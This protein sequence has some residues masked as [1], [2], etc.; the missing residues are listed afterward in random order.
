MGR[1]NVVEVATPQAWIKTE[2]WFC[3]F[4]N[5]RRKQAFSVQPNQGHRVLTELKE[6]FNVSIITQNVDVP[7][8]CG[9]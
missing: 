8:E 9:K 3:N 7:R 2:Y 5:Q 1:D 6:Y 4:N